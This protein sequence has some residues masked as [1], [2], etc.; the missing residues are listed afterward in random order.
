MQNGK[1]NP[2]R[3][4]CFKDDWLRS[5][6]RMGFSLSQELATDIVLQSLPE[7]YSQF[8]MNY[9]MKDL[10]KPLPDLLST[11]RNTEA[12]MKKFKPGQ[13]QNKRQDGQKLRPKASPRH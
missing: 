10:D 1:R 13:R 4:T 2:S 9:N 11:L 6:G 12:N 8:V 3:N 5:L 7:S